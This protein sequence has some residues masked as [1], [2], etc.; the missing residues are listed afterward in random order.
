MIETIIKGFIIGLAY[1]APIGMQNLYVI[2][3]AISQ[4][5]SQMYFVVI[6]TTF[7]DISLSLASFFGIGYAMSKLPILKLIILCLGS[8][9]IIIIGFQLLKSR[10]VIDTSIK[11][12][13]NI[14]KIIL[15]CFLVTWANPQAILD[16]TMLFGSLRAS[17]PDSLITYFIL[18]ACTS[19]IVWFFSLGTFVNILK[20]SFNSQVLKIINILCGIIVIYYGCRIGYNFLIEI[21]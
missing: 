11:T 6:L 13:N 16:S 17:I 12:N 15:S 3:S 19:S 10:P 1:L 14:K 18:G 7:F 9:T 21:L 8:L 4:K 20:K 2:N 5:K